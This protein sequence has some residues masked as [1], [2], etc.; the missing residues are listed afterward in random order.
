MEVVKNRKIVLGKYKP[1]AEGF[2]SP[3]QGKL[4]PL[5]N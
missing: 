5:H 1:T 2:I 3:L 4:E